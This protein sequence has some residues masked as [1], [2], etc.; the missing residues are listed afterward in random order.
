MKKYIFLLFAVTLF[1]GCEESE[2]TNFNEPDAVYF[3][4]KETDFSLLY[5]RW[6]DWLDYKGDSVVYSFGGT[7]VDHPEYIE[8]DTVWLQVNLQGHVSSVT[9]HYK[10]I[11]N[12]NETTVDE[13]VQYE[14]LEPQYDFESD[15]VRTS[16]P[17]VLHNHESL[18]AE[19]LTLYLQLE[20]TDDFLLGLEGRTVARILIYNDVIKPE[21]WDKYLY[22]H[23]G[24]YSKAKHKVVLMTNGGKLVPNTY[25]EYNQVGGYYE[26]RSWRS[27]M[28]A[29]L[30]ANEVYDE[31]GNRVEP[32]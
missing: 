20:E 2:L 28:N 8:Q 14:A 32:W 25:S 12:P 27:P 7:P 19:P 22:R 17:V 4:L 18:G 29:Y 21:I 3:Q 13:G 11:V 6:D 5:D 9:R 31:N 10:V 15:T 30:E 26:I 24:P 1:V 16:F 23:L